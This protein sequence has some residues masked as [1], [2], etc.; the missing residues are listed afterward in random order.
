[1]KLSSKQKWDKNLSGPDLSRASSPTTCS[2]PLPS[3]PSKASFGSLTLSN[4]VSL[5]CLWPLI[6]GMPF[7]F[8]LGND[9]S[10]KNCDNPSCLFLSDAG[11]VLAR[12]II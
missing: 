6:S 7:I 5:K 2:H 3:V 8:M 1:M 9:K 11:L 12:T 10:T 4:N